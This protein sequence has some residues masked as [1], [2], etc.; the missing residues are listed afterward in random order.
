MAL[1]LRLPQQRECRAGP[2]PGGYVGEAMTSG[3]CFEG[4]CTHLVPG[5]FPTPLYETIMCLLLFAC[6]GGCASG[7]PCRGALLRY[8]IL[9]GVERFFIE[10]I[11][12]NVPFSAIGPRPS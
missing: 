5:V 4:Y 6:C 9:N 10:Q 12:V 1:E 11:R 2:P 7:S 8:L 3:T